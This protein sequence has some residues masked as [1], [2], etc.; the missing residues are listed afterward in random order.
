MAGESH[1]SGQMFTLQSH[2]SAGYPCPNLGPRPRPPVESAPQR[3]LRGCLQR[4]DRSLIWGAHAAGTART[5]NCP[6]LAA[7][8]APIVRR[9]TT[10][11]AYGP[12]RC[13]RKSASKPAPRPLTLPMNLCVCEQAIPCPDSMTCLKCGRSSLN[14]AASPLPARRFGVDWRDRLLKHRRRENW[15]RLN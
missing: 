7:G 3:G 9:P 2:D 14:G 10:G 5:L 8:R 6:P 4:A 15:A 1:P 11:L 12:D 13:G